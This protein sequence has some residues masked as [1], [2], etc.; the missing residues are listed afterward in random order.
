MGQLSMIEE[1]H[2]WEPYALEAEEKSRM[3]SRELIELTRFHRDAPQPAADHMLFHGDHQAVPRE[4]LRKSFPVN[5]L[6]AGTAAAKSGISHWAT[7]DLAFI[8]ALPNLTV[9][10]PADSSNADHILFRNSKIQKLIR[11]FFRISLHAG[12]Q[13]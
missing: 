5:G 4:N 2:Q 12:E 6:S 11:V 10:S 3:L 9:F 1:F 7:E 13:R 8:R